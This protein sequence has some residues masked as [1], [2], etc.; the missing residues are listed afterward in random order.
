MTL[1]LLDFCAYR[2][3]QER[4]SWFEFP[5]LKTLCEAV[6]DCCFQHLPDKKKIWQYVCHRAISRL[7]WYHNAFRRGHL[8][9]WHQIANLF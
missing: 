6:E 1:S 3:M 9:K 8:G 5:Y 4:T 7:L 2:A